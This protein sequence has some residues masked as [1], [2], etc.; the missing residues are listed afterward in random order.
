MTPSSGTDRQRRHGLP[1]APMCNAGMDMRLRV[2]AAAELFKTTGNTTY[3]TY[4]DTWVK[5]PG[6]ERRHP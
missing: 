4:F 1:P 3:R 5:D 6:T 2:L